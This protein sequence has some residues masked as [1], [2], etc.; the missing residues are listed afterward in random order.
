[1][2]CVLRVECG[3]L[4]AVVKL[5]F[6]GYFEG[7]LNAKSWKICRHSQPIS[8]IILFFA[9]KETQNRAK[10]KFNNSA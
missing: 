9:A 10:N 2:C 1:M 5:I 8:K 7:F 6:A 4:G 3:G